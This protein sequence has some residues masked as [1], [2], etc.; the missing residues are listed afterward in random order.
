MIK[1]CTYFANKMNEIRN[2]LGTDKC[3]LYLTLI[4]NKN[5]VVLNMLNNFNKAN[6]IKLK[7]IRWDEYYNIEGTRGLGYV[8]YG[9]ALILKPNTDSGKK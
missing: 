9:D 6:G 7:Y 2:D 1:V 3:V 5:N 4:R 8:K